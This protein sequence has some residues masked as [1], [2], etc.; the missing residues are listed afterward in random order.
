MF[1]YAS[2]LNY[3]GK[4][5]TRSSETSIGLIRLLI[6]YKH[7]LLEKFGIDSFTQCPV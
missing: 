7:A 1:V 2:C 6:Q 4:T 3:C 5:L